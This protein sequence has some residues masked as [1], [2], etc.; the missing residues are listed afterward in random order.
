M[1]ASPARLSQSLYRIVT[2]LTM[3]VRRALLRGGVHASRTPEPVRLPAHF[4][5]DPSARDRYVW[6]PEYDLGDRQE[7]GYAY[8]LHPA[9]GATCYRRVQ[10]GNH[11]SHEFLMVL[12]ARRIA[13]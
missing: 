11:V 5:P 1:R 6:V 12:P 9:S 3:A 8:Y 4:V 7:E 13:A 2:A 10:R